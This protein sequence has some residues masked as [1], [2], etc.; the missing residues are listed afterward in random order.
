MAVALAAGEVL[1]TV[2]AAVSKTIVTIAVPFAKVAVIM[3]APDTRL[4]ELVH[5]VRVG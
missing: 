4:T 2:G 5:V 3:F 1:D